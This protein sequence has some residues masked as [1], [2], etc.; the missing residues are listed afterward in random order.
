[1]PAGV[2]V[3]ADV[4]RDRDPDMPELPG[5]IDHL[6]VSCEFAARITGGLDPAE[7]ARALWQPGRREV[8]VTCGAEGCWYTG[9]G[10]NR[11]LHHAA[12]MVPVCDTTGCGDVFHGAYASALARGVPLQ[13]RIR[14]ASA[15]AA[16][17]ATRPGGQ[18][19]IPTRAAVENFIAER[20]PLT[21]I[22][23]RP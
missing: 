12:Y 7:A 20:T 10:G 13:E 19:D 8:V 3:V 17:K 6:I 4:E 2:P 16:I 11:P 21:P 18:A 15:A 1:L 14:F 22:I 23:R 5:L 9:D